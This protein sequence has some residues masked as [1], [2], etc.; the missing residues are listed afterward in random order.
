MK[1]AQFFLM[2]SRAFAFTVV[3]RK[4]Q[5]TEDKCLRLDSPGIESTIEKPEDMNTAFVDMLKFEYEKDFVLDFVFKKTQ[6][7]K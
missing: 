3:D 4:S 1:N 6:K 7:C 2:K 5:A